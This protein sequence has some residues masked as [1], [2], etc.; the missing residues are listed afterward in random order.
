MNPLICIPSVTSTDLT[1]TTIYASCTTTTESI[2]EYLSSTT[3]YCITACPTES[4]RV[5]TYLS[6]GTVIH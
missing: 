6:D 3:T 2:V 5:N 4:Y 1:E